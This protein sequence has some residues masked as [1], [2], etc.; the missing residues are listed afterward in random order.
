MPKLKA[1]DGEELRRR[2]AVLNQAFQQLLRAVGAERGAPL[3]KAGRAWV[4]SSD[5][6]CDVRMSAEAGGQD[7]PLVCS[8]CRL[9]LL[10]CRIDDLQRALKAARS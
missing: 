6:E 7:A 10:A 9:E 1:C 5:A 2:D 4:A 8:A 3:R